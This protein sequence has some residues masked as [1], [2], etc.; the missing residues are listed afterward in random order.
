MTRFELDD[1]LVQ[2]WDEEPNRIVVMVT[3]D[4]DESLYLADRLL[5]M[6]DGPAARMCWSSWTT[7]RTRAALRRRCQ[8]GIKRGLESAGSKGQAGRQV[9]AA[10][11]E[12]SAGPGLCPGPAV[13]TGASA[14]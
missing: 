14:S 6:T 2:V 7:T 5:L 12:G 1:L 13:A 3:H 4:I 10:A 8:G 11:G 9:E